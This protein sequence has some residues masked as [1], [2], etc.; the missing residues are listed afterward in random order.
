[1]AELSTPTFISPDALNMPGYALIASPTLYPGQEISAS[2]MSAV[3]ARA[4]LFVD[5][6]GADDQLERKRAGWTPVGAS[7]HVSL[8]FVPDV[9]GGSP[10]A[11]VGL[12]VNAERPG[13]LY[14]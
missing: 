7:E 13:I 1:E 8:R 11:R 2:V 12:L 9:D 14:L 10:I 6:Y 4:R 5:V 3:P